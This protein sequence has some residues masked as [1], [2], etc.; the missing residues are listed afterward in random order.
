MVY[1]KKVTAY[2]APMAAFI[3]LLAL[4]SLF[5]RLGSA[6]WL[7]HPE[8][9]VYPLQTAVCAVLLSIFWRTYE[10]RAPRRL[11][12]GLAVGILMFIIWIAPQ[13]FLRFAPRTTGFNP[14]V[15]SGQAGLYWF[16]VL[17]RFLRLVVVVPLVEEI[18]WPGFLLRYLINERFDQVAFG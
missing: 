1:R 4:D 11:T 6:F 10:L 14:E 17:V 18:F 8:Y 12:I 5:P 3:A 7:Q 9:W 2:V 13:V 15:F 16:A